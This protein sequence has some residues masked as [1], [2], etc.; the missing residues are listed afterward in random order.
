MATMLRRLS[1][2]MAAVAAQLAQATREEEKHDE[3]D[4]EVE[5]SDE[6]D[7]DYIDDDPSIPK[8]E[9][10]LRRKDWDE[11]HW[12]DVYAL[13]QREMLLIYRPEGIEMCAELLEAID[14]RDI[15][16]VVDAKNGVLQLILPS[17]PSLGEARNPVILCGPAM[18]D[19][20][21]A[22]GAAMEM[23]GD[24][25]LLISGWLLKRPLPSSSA[26][27]T[28]R[29]PRERYVRVSNHYLR[30]F[31]GEGVGE[32]ELGSLNLVLVESVAAAVA[33]AGG[34]F[35]GEGDG[36]GGLG[37]IFEVISEHRLFIFE[38]GS[39]ADMKLWVET[40]ELARRAAVAARDERARA[41]YVASCP[42][43]VRLYDEQGRVAYCDM[44]Y[45]DL[46]DMY[47][48]D[49]VPDGG[50]GG[51]GGGGGAE[52]GADD[53]DDDLSE[54]GQHMSCAT[55]LV[56]YLAGV[57]PEVQ[58]GPALP[59]ARYDVLGLAMCTINAFL[60]MRMAPLFDLGSG[61]QRSPPGS[62]S[63]VTG[64]GSGSGVSRASITQSALDRASMTELHA[65]IRWIGKYSHVLSTVHC[66]VATTSAS[67]TAI[68]PSSDGV[69]G[70][71]RG[72]AK[73][74]A[75][76]QYPT[77]TP[78]AASAPAPAPAPAP[79][80]CELLCTALPG[81][82]AFIAG[83]TSPRACELFDHVRELCRLYVHGGGHG[84]YVGGSGSSSSGRGG[85]GGGGGNGDDTWTPNAGQ[86]GHGG[87]GAHLTAHAHKVW[88]A[89]TRAPADSLQRHQDGSFHTQAPPDMWR[90]FHQ[91]LT[92]AARTRCPILHVMVA[93][94]IA[95]VLIDVTKD[96]TR[97]ILDE[98]DQG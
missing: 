35:G 22:L 86:S 27:G 11:G 5:L 91:H 18:D 75:S 78:A 19:W 10:L 16:D 67:A 82:A 57:I 63:F 85:G 68:S 4:D 70:H 60:W 76:H 38:T 93:E 64:S 3:D 74:P 36:G 79:Y 26:H 47:P 28:Q 69:P 7:D 42:Y 77:N 56:D 15:M 58:R 32:Q 31:K 6:D 66:P 48:S 24:K 45:L 83:Q 89:L 46:C 43:R 97:F 98:M 25:G 41:L 87:A 52:A 96:I 37:C 59:E 20:A 94:K 23:F 34:A 55:K 51:G 73:T 95:A 17:D 13:L 12:D 53:L 62:S 92:L 65:L 30:Y 72:T 39:P 1:T 21:A 44:I 71:G 33:G 8:M 61:G 40:I 54:L 90:G 84:C 49:M 2:N 14:T 88:R 29:A 81:Y 9:G 80:P 50:G